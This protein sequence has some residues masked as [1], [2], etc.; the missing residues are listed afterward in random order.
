VK[1]GLEI[2]VILKL[3]SKGQH[4]L[5]EVPEGVGVAL[6]VALLLGLDRISRSL[7]Q[8]TLQ[9]FFLGLTG[10]QVRLWSFAAPLVPRD[11]PL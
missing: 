2:T 8:L 9:P 1:V 5:A 4:D 7:L 10:F 6:L 11:E 3:A